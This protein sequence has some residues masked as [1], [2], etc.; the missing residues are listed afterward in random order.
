MANKIILKKSSVADKIPT[1]SDLE[2][3][4]LALNYRDGKQFYKTSTNTIDTFASIDATA[5]LTNKTLSSP[6]IS[7]GT[8]NNA[9][10]GGTTPAAVTGSTVTSTGNLISSNSSGDDGG[11][12]L[13]HKPQTNTTIA[14]TGVTIDVYQN[15]LRIFEQGGDARGVYIDITAAAS[16]VAT[17]LIAAAGG[18]TVT[19]I[20]AGT[21]LTGGTISTSG[22]IA[23]D[24]TVAT[25]DGTQTLTN[26]TIA[27][28]SNTISG[29]T[30]SNLSGTAGISNANLANSS[31][32]I[33]STT[34]SLGSTVTTFA[35]LS[36]VTS[37]T[38]VGALTGNAST[39]TNVAYTGLTGTVPTWNQNTT[40]T[41]SNVTGTVA[42]ANG[43]TGETT[44]QAAL[45]ALAG[46]VTAGQYLRGDGTDVV[47][48]AIQAADV[49]TLN[50]NTTGSAATLTTA[51]TINGVSF[52]GSENITVTANTTNALTI[53]TGL[54]GTSF[55]G[56]GAVTVAID[57]TVATLT[58][59]QTLTNKTI[60]GA[61]NTLSNI[62]NASL[63][64]S[65]VTVG[66]T[67]IS[68]GASATTIAGLSSVTS[69]TFVGALTGNAST[70]TTLQTARTIS[71]GGDL[72]GSV[73]FNGSADVTIT[74]TVAANSV[75]LGT[76][77]TGNYVATIA[78]TTNQ[79]TVS[80][81]GS[82][83]AAV[84]LSLPQN[85]HTGATPQFAGVTLTGALAMG[86]NKITGLGTPTDATDATTKQYVDEVA[87]GLKAA[88]AVEVA[89]TA[90]LTATYSNGTAGVGATL[91]STSN[92]AF[93]TIDG[94]TVS[95]TATGQNGVLVKNQSTAAHNGRY[96]LTQVGNG[97]T[98]WILTRCG[99][100][101]QASEIP[102]SYVFV[103]GGTTQASTGWVAYVVNPS[104]YVVGTDS[105]TYFQFSGAG[106]YTAGT[107]LTLTGS[108]FSVNAAQT[109]ITSVGTLTGG[110]WNAS[111]IAG[112]YGGTGVAN[113][114]K[115]ITIGGNF[116][117]SGAHT[118][119]LTTSGNT[120]VTLPTSGTLATLAGT[121]TLTNKTL[122]S[123]TL[124]TPVLG[125]PSSG[126]LTN[127]TGLPNAGLV[128]SAVTIGSTSVSLGA[129][130]T[131]FAGLSSVTSTTF[132]GALTGNVTGNVTGSSGSCTG[133]SGTATTLQTAR[134]IGGVSF[135]G[136]ANINLPGVNTAGNQ[137][138][139]GTAAISTAATITTSATASAFKVPF[140]NTTAS[141]T[142]NYGLLQDSEATFTYNPSTNTLTV[143]TVAAALS[144]NA[145]T[146]TTLATGRTIAITG[147]LTYT[148]GS[149][150]GSA[151]VTGTGTLANSGVTA[152]S[153]TSANITVDAK[154]RVT[155]ASSGSS[156]GTWTRRTSNY[157]AVN[158][159]LIIADT[160]GGAFTITLPAS[161]TTG[162]IVTIVDGA[163]WKTTNLTI[164]RN[165][166]TIEGL[167][168]NLVVDLGG[169]RLDLIY[170]GTTWEVFSSLGPVGDA[171]ANV[172][173]KSLGVGTAPSGT[174]GQIRANDSVISFYSDQRLKENITP[175]QDPINKL[176]QLNGVVYTANEVAE[177][178]GFKDKS[179]QVGV[180]A[181][182]LE[183]VLPHVVKSAPFDT[184]FTETG[185][186]YSISGENYKTVQ[187]E[188]IV[189]L[190][191]EAI[192]EQQKMIEDLQ[193]KIGK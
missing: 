31:V 41:A 113:T 90:N 35:G 13:L 126:T 114:G 111:V 97:S 105:I 79:V 164:A 15:R 125:T 87:Q 11:E 119:T 98:P 180:I 170:D 122:T 78:G 88:P 139:S 161:P 8:I 49:P 101:D 163:N 142:G 157:T 27:A 173:F 26:K 133:N 91:T 149:F 150:N 3:G 178:Y 152:G 84:T 167:A 179:E 137:N 28:G 182:D 185:E 183:K 14:G 103:K 136:S 159:D 30:N 23:I 186:E 48:S 60:S 65:A 166:A 75:A 42:I 16:G 176:M 19:S 2:Y 72:S 10:I 37:T 36:S 172:Q 187:Y 118:T 38:F 43:G 20:T 45:D 141:T 22:T 52:N 12:I 74:A 158:N 188:K 192:K 115:T 155:A 151:N 134:T 169:C 96:N 121:E 144:G 162:N 123:P 165:S 39:A 127:C 130:V 18:G 69:T 71:L 147:D 32:T 55:N 99:V 107:G 81:S 68:L 21:G 145:T 53:G 175:I 92:G 146:A 76:D 34:V 100:C 95:S 59:T 77:T 51:R 66:S 70:A 67:S 110:T 6:T 93:P 80:G 109:Q 62:A 58:G 5:T 129:T 131:T 193:Q 40:G 153:Y 57:S 46:A 168:E 128:N 112:Q 132:V 47:M 83:T 24:S 189:P 117:T 120:S 4:E 116:T 61:S 82:E 94:V 64:N 184:G 54:S 9:V 33:G 108:A 104:T 174:S 143:G 29:L 25:L 148:S 138:T 73:S 86:S 44:R 191:I 56:S 124:T 106:T 140:A 190:L 177:K 1:D 135:N 171:T 63:T 156:A 160:A 102:G 85:I 50:Q 89:T 181:Q 17:N 7:G 154:G